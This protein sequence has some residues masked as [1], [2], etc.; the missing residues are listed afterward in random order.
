M[1]ENY[2]E[3]IKEHGLVGAGGAGFPTHVKVNAKAKYVL[4]NGAECEPLIRVDQQLMALKTKEIIIALEYVRNLVEADKAIIGL[5]GKYKEAIKASGKVIEDYDHIE[6]FK[7]GNFYP[8]GDEQVLVYEALGL[9]VPE[10]GIPL[11]VGVVVL[12]VETL[13]NIYNAITNDS[14]VIEKYI[15]VGGHVNQPVTVKVPIGITFKEVIDLAGGSSLE[16]YSVINGG[17]MMGKLINSLDER[18][19]KS[20]KA[21][22]VLPKNHGLVRTLNK[23][24]NQMLREAKTACMHCSLCS[25]VC[26][27]NLIG[28]S[29]EPHK[30]IRLASYGSTCEASLKTTTAFLCCECRLCEYACVMNLQPWKL[31]SILKGQMSKSGIRNPHHDAPESVHP[32]R[33]IKRYPVSKL[34]KQL[35]LSSYD[36]PA[37]IIEEVGTFKEVSILLRQHIG[38]PTKAVVEAGQFVEKGQVVGR[39]GDS[40]LGTNVHASISGFV[41]SVSDE[42]VRIKG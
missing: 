25:E 18:V 6:V 26:P 31:H 29:I 32:F 14:P 5:K 23:D 39:I 30:L 33:E 40:Q 2:V 1:V 7:L 16:N 9:I 11:N 20:T 12:N 15:T 19:S 13:L 38:A 17:P 37:P 34:I 35:D 41:T 10:G 42:E 36:Q 4:V 21:L 28:H 24:F 8:A 27:R 22:L 3:R